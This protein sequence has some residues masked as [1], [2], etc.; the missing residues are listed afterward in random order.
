MKHK[1][2]FIVPLAAVL[3]ASCSSDETDMNGISN[4][5]AIPIRL[6]TQLQQPTRAV[7]QNTSVA[8][9]EKVY[10]WCDRTS[11][12]ANWFNSWELTADG[13]NHLTSTEQKYYPPKSGT[14]VNFYAIHGAQTFTD[15]QSAFPTA[16]YTHTVEAD[17]TTI[18]NYA[19]S[20]LLYGCVQGITHTTDSVPIT[21][22]HMLSNIRVVV[23]STSTAIS[24]SLLKL[25]TVELLNIRPTTSFLPVKYG[26]DDAGMADQTKRAAMLTLDE[27]VAATTIKL[28]TVISPSNTSSTT[29]ESDGDHAV[30]PPQ[31]LAAGNVIRVTINDTAGNYDGLKLYAALSED[32]TLQSG[33]YYTFHVAVSPTELSLDNITIN[34]WTAETTDRG[35]DIDPTD[36]NR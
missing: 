9:D 14:Q 34:E 30:V 17:Q 2:A 11:T 1:I 12:N 8:K 16:A 25:A 5:S 31:T 32:L 23:R 26:A 27:S 3:L 35:G 36:F 19:K 21:L 15:G 7:A 24:D 10:V 33:Y 22:Y 28:N 4:D 6:A 13:N 29:W 18:A 20:D